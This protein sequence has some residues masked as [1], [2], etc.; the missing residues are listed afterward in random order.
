MSDFLSQSE[1]RKHLI[2]G[3]TISDIAINDNVSMLIESFIYNENIIHG[4]SFLIFL[5]HTVKL[6]IYYIDI[7][8]LLIKP[9][10][11]ADINHLIMNFMY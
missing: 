6:L 4:Y 11:V 3:L 5:E 10:P 2:D 8:K 1:V 7:F 9:I